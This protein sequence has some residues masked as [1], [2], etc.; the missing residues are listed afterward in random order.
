MCWTLWFLL[1]IF[2]N[3]ESFVRRGAA[4]CTQNWSS[5]TRAQNKDW[6]IRCISL[7]IRLWSTLLCSGLWI[8]FAYWTA[9]VCIMYMICVA[10]EK[11]KKRKT[12]LFQWSN[13]AHELITHGSLAKMMRI[14]CDESTP[15]PAYIRVYRDLVFI[16]KK[17]LFALM[18]PFLSQ[19]ISLAVHCVY[20][21]IYLSNN[22]N[23]IYGNT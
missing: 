19:C 15:R 13:R 14:H 2:C 10:N 21:K 23:G 7:F 17:R 22:G 18:L 6:N 3:I 8:N 20:P 5:S 9:I 12:S 11:E 1:F 16:L 4:A